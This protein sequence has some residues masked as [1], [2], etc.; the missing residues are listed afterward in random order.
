MKPLAKDRKGLASGNRPLWRTLGLLAGLLVVAMVSGLWLASFSVP[1]STATAQGPVSIA[2]EPASQTVDPGVTFDVAVRIDPQGQ[3]VAAADVYIDFD[4]VY[5]SVMEIV[6]GTGLSIFVKN[7][8]NATGTIDVGAG[9]L[10]SPVTSAFTLVTLR[11]QGKV[12]TGSTPTQLRFSFASGRVT[13]VKNESDQD[14]LGAHTNGQVFITGATVTPAPPTPTSTATPTRTATPTHTPTGLPTNTPTVSPTPTI[15]P[16]PVG[17]PVTLWFQNG[18]SPNAA[19]SGTKDTC[20]DNYQPGAVLGGSGDMRLRHDGNKRALIKFDLSQH[21]PFG[22]AVVEAKLSLWMYYASAYSLVTYADAYRVNRPWEEMATTWNSPWQSGGCSAVPGDREGV[23]AATAKLWNFLPNNGVWVEFDIT[24]LVQ[25]WVSGSSANEGILII[26]KEDVSREVGFRTANFTDKTQRPKL[27]VRF[28]P[29]PPTPT[30][31]RTST[32]TNTPT[33]TPTYTPT[34]LPGAIDGQV[35][36]DLNGNGVKDGGEPTLAGATVR[37]YEYA[38]PPPEP[39]IRPE[40]VT[41][42]DGA[43][44]FM[45]LPPGSYIVVETNP[46]GYVST[47][48]DMVN[49]WVA[50]G[51]THPVYFG[52][53]IPSTPTASP[54]GTR[55]P[56]ATPTAT[57]LRPYRAFLPVIRHLR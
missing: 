36:N 53:W 15:T 37:L 43:F 26:E 5:L 25:G 52:D 28:F 14:I 4:P 30:P 32:P 3:G 33:A 56:A 34:P 8:N 49:V 17:T 1:A 27:M 57:P 19:Y 47:T 51:F 21:I 50:S 22:S 6:D 9:T 16:T 11:L 18:V 13:V 48:S 45:D 20:L 55:T 29:A 24:S 54:T 31:T 2:M 44:R 23:A 7:Y 35:W 39:P 42:T 41:G 10:G 46:P 12:G 40:V 38:H